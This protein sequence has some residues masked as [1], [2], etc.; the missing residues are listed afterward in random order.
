MLHPA[1]PLRRNMRTRQIAGVCSGLA[2]HFGLDL[3]LVR[4]GYVVATV[5]SAGTALAIY[6]ILWLVIPESE[7]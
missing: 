5:L 2:E 1:A 4:I 7:V 6:V 3:T